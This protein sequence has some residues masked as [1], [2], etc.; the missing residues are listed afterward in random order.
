MIM[1]D[2]LKYTYAKVQHSFAKSDEHD[3]WK[4]VGT[5]ECDG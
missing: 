2:N 5:D 4:N 1:R 3:L